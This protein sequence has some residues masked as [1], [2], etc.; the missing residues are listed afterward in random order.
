M[1]VVRAVH[2]SDSVGR[3]DETHHRGVASVCNS[4]MGRSDPRLF[5]E[6]AAARQP[7]SA[8][9]PE[10]AQPDHP[11]A[12]ALNHRLAKVRP[13]QGVPRACRLPGFPRH[14]HTKFARSRWKRGSVHRAVSSG[15]EFEN[16]LLARSSASRPNLNR[17]ST[18]SCSSDALTLRVRNAA[19]RRIATSP[20]V[21]VSRCC[22]MP[23]RPPNFPQSLRASG[24]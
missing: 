14:A 23:S 3:D 7:P 11:R 10:F 22:R 13:S 4:R 24:V 6:L 8:G 16:T 5:Q 1:R 17:C 9:G 15:R 21:Y 2:N 20:V 19:D 18:G 12:N